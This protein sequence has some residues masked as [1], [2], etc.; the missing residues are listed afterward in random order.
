M[1][2]QKNTTCWFSIKVEKLYFGSFGPK[3]P[4]DFFQTKSGPVTFSVR[5]HPG[6]MQKI[7][8]LQAVPKKSPGKQRNGQIYDIQK[9]YFIGTSIRGSN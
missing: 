4:H 8:F 6:F 5:W 1:K 2:N 9:E 3:N 7:R